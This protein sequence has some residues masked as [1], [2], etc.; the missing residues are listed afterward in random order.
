MKSC[1]TDLYNAVRDTAENHGEVELLGVF[2]ALRL[3]LEERGLMD[4]R[5]GDKLYD[6]LNTAEDYLRSRVSAAS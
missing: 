5:D 6:H 2:S 4:Y 1:T 3:V